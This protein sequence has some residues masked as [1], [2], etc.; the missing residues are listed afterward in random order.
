MIAEYSPDVVV[1]D[2][3][4]P[5]LNGI[6]AIAQAH[7]DHPAVRV[8]V[9]SMHDNEEY[10][11]QALRAGA[12]AYLLKDSSPTELELAV[13]AV[14]RGGSY[15]SPMVSR[16]VVSDYL[17]RT[18][19]DDAHVGRAD[20]APARDPPAH[21]RGPHQ[22]QMATG[23]NLSIKTVESHRAQL[24]DRLAHPRRRRPGALRDPRRPDR[25]RPL[26]EYPRA[27]ARNPGFEP[28]PPARVSTHPD[29]GTAT[30][31]ER[32]AGPDGLG[33]PR[34]AA[35]VVH[36]AGETVR[37]E[38]TWGGP[39]GRTMALGRQA[40]ASECPRPSARP[41]DPLHATCDDRAA[42]PLADREGLPLADS[43]TMPHP[44]PGASSR[45]AWCS[46]RGCWR[47]CP[48]AIAPGRARG[49]PRAQRAAAAP[50]LA[51]RHLARRADSPRSR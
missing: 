21:R 11:R 36:T 32:V 43:R 48:I 1:M 38:G 29:S 25:R 28:G 47:G 37:H 5:G 20:P 10:V 14:A 45:V 12:A 24:M 33:D 40:C 17:R 16:H 27:A 42:P 15:L 19:S 2:L 44:R 23:L 49:R 7:L 6:Q 13:R 22:P 3:T 50:P 30:D 46:T 41:R 51:A 18:S 35:S 8:I 26:G 9:L 4:M 31:A 34:R 39:V